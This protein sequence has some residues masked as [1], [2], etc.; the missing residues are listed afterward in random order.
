MTTSPPPSTSQ[1]PPFGRSPIAHATTCRR[2]S[3]IEVSLR[4]REAVVERFLEV[5]K[6]GDIQA[7]LDVL[8][9]D[10]G[11]VTDGGGKRR[12][13]IKPIL[14]RDKVMRFMSGVNDPRVVAERRTVNGG[15]ALCVTIDGEVDTLVTFLWRTA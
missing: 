8:A 3:L 12:A 10:V 13:A 7:L 15:P 5:A 4:E 6:G 11:L 14:G 9:P 2:V 1:R